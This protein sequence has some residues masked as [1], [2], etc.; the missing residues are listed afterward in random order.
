MA[1]ALLGLILLAAGRQDLDG[2]LLDHFFQQVVGDR[3]VEDGISRIAGV[4]DVEDVL[5]RQAIRDLAQGRHADG[6]PEESSRVAIDRDQI[7]LLF[8]RPER[9]GLSVPGEEHQHAVV[10]P[11]LPSQ[12]VT[13]H[14][15]DPVLRR[16]PVDERHDP[17]G[18]EPLSQQRA[19]DG[20]RVVHGVAQ[21]GDP[22]MLVVVDTDDDRPRVD[23]EPAAAGLAHRLRRDGAGLG[24]GRERARQQHQPGKKERPHGTIFT[25]SKVATPETTM[26][27]VSAPL[28]A[29]NVTRRV[30]ASPLLSR[31]VE[32]PSMVMT[33]YVCPV[34]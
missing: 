23:V 19:L 27:I 22:W 25:S 32:K 24:Q 17:I 8:A 5:G 9:V 30:F 28:G 34:A 6:R 4:H 12:L 1:L 7:A 31:P 11:D 10:R 15:F 14:A 26:P 33:G 13:E 18:T 20:A 29:L 2:R 3:A 21:L 16:F